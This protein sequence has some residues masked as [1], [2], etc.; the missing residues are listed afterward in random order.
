MNPNPVHFLLTRFN[1]R[2]KFDIPPRD[3]PPAPGL[4]PGW[5][6]RRFALYER[7]CLPSVE[8]QTVRDFRWLVFMDEETPARFRTR[9]E[10]LAEKHSFLL[11]VFCREFTGKEVLRHMEIFQPAGSGLRITSRLDND[12]MLH[13]RYIERVRSRACA[14]IAAGRDAEQGFFIAFPLGCCLRGADA[15]IQRYRNNPFVS[16][17]SLP[18]ASRTV[19]DSDH[20]Y[21]ADMAP[22]VHEWRAPMWCQVIHG[23]NVANALRGVYWPFERLFSRK[24]SRDCSHSAVWRIREFCSTAVRYVTRS[25]G[26]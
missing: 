16:Y 12:D 15:Y 7:Y 10:T 25:Q 6:E 11:P 17:V 4:D 23:E 13:P 21:I 3:I 1:V 26:R 20:R 24:A 19:L 22:V 2:L 18:T 14:E 8:E 9:M 5:L